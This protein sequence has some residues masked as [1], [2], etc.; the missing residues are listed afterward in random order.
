[1]A[2]AFSSFNQSEVARLI[3]DVCGCKANIDVLTGGK[4]KEKL[5]K[6]AKNTRKSK[7]TSD[8]DVDV[9]KVKSSNEKYAL[10]ARMLAMLEDE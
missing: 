6:Q 10:I 9:V 4:W 7:V 5:P 2:S 8:V 3:T 1:M